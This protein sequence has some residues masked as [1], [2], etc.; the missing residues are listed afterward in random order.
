MEAKAFA[1]TE[2]RSMAK[3]IEYWAQMG[4]VALDNPDLPI[5]FIHDTLVALN[6][7]PVKADS[8]D[9]FFDAL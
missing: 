1:K 9:A 8:V 6:E 2:H 7:K 4:R 3:Q 5:T